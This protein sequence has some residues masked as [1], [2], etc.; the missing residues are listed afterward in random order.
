MYLDLI[1][2]YLFRSTIF[3]HF[4]NYTLMTDKNPQK[5]V[6]IPEFSRY[7]IYHGFMHTFM[8]IRNFYWLLVKIRIN[9]ISGINEEA[10]SWFFG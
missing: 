2:V 5:V 4:V 9:I 8:K 6:W 3:T 7:G 10:A 1:V